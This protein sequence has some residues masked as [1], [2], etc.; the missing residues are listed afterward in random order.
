MA[1]GKKTK[2]VEMTF[3][4]IKSVSPS[5]KKDLQAIAKNYDVD[6]GSLLKPKLRELANSYP[7]EMRIWNKY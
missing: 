7:P 5:L 6:L 4:M 2:R 3:I 1:K